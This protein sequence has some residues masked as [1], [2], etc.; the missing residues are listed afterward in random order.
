MS[1]RRF[2]ALI[3]LIA[4]SACGGDSEGSGVDPRLARLDA[5]DAQRQRVLGDPAM[6]VTGMPLT[7]E[8][9][10]PS[11]G[12]ADFTGAATIQIAQPETVL[13]L[14]GDATLTI[15]FDDLSAS[16]SVTRIFGDTPDGG[17]ADYDGSLTLSGVADGAAFLLDYAGAL[18][19]GTD[20]LTFDGTLETVLLGNPIAGFSA[21][22]L[23]ALIELAGGS[24]EG[25][26]V[27]FGEGTVTQP[28][29]MP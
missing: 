10:V 24:L 16:G 15:A 20:A 28:E 2:L 12:Q 11:T 27:I 25:T 1:V 18:T 29:P 9:A 5:Y 13:S 21:S 14:A 4:A 22:E 6:G 26:V 3:A 17:F 7:P 8:D 19:A 23:E